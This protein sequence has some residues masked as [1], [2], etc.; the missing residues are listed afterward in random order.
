MVE[1][2]LTLD[3]EDWCQSA[4]DVFGPYTAGTRPPVM[5]TAR[6][7]GNTARL[8]DLLGAFGAIRSKGYRR[9]VRRSERYLITAYVDRYLFRS[10]QF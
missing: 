7:V 6:V 2:I 1:N 9:A 5:P 8:L 10:G 4:P 3:I